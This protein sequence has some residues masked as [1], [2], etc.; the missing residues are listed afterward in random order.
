M[1]Y[2]EREVGEVLEEDGHGV[3]QI[4]EL[5][6]PDVFAVE[7]D[8]SLL[9]IIQTNTEF[10]DCTLSGAVCANDHLCSA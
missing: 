3:T 2:G 9:R 4:N 5:E 6:S 7:K 8:F 1:A 10:E